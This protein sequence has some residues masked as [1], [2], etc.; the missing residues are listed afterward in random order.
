MKRIFLLSALLTFAVALTAQTP[1][2][3]TKRLDLME[4]NIALT[5]EERVAMEQLMVK[6]SEDV[7]GLSQEEAKKF[8]NGFTK[9]IFKVIGQRRWHQARAMEDKTSIAVP[10]PVQK[11]A[12][13]IAKDLSLTKEQAKQV[14]EIMAIYNY[15]SADLKE[16]NATQQEINTRYQGLINDL[17]AVVG[18]RD[19]VLRGMQAIRE[20]EAK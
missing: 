7:A 1:R 11:R 2:H 10:P 16:R 15:D 6:Y 13:I 9:E 3:I 5:S 12:A 18:G 20:A 17:A 19:R 14:E 4:K 8:Y